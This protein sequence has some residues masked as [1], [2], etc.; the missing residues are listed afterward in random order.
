MHGIVVHYIVGKKRGRVG[1]SGEENS[2][3]WGMRETLRK[4]PIIPGT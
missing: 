2:Q 4:G 3:L 1:D